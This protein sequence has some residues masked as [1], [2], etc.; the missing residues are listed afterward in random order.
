MAAAAG[1]T[2]PTP[3]VQ[4]RAEET[5]RI[6]VWKSSIAGEEPVSCQQE[7]LISLHILAV[8]ANSW[9]GIDGA[10]EL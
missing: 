6:P 7:P 4:E 9:L 3:D 2:T 5:E 1:K 8:M 10:E